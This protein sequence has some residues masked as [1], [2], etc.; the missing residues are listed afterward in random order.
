MKPAVNITAFIIPHFPSN[1]RS[2]HNIQ[3]SNS[4][5]TAEIRNSIQ[6]LADLFMKIEVFWIRRRVFERVFLDFSKERTPSGIFSPLTSTF[7][8]IFRHHSFIYTVSNLRKR[9][10]EVTEV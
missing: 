6:V 5:T 7:P 10:S 1:F 4:Q 3:Y 9:E 8:S 2:A